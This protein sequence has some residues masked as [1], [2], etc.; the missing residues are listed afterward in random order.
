MIDIDKIILNEVYLFLA[1]GVKKDLIK[2]YPNLEQ[3]LAALHPKYIN[4]LNARFGDNAKI[5]EI[6]PIEDVIPTLSLFDQR[7]QSIK[8]KS[9]NQDFVELVTQNIGRKINPAD[10][11]NLTADEI[12]TIIGLSQRKKQRIDVE[13]KSVIKDEEHIGKVGPWN[14]WLPHTRESSCQIAGYD[15]VTRKEKTTWCTARMSGSNLFYSY[16]GASDQRMLLFYV[17]K[18]DP[19]NNDDWLSVGYVDGKIKFDGQHGGISVNRANVG[20]TDDTFGNIVGKYEK[21]IIN[22]MDKAAEGLSGTHPAYEKIEQAAKSVDAYKYLIKG[23][24]SSEKEDL[25]LKIVRELEASPEVL[26]I[27]AREGDSTIRMSVVLNSGVS[28][29]IL[30]K[31]SRD[32]HRFVRRRVANSDSD[33][34][35]TDAL[36]SL[37]KDI[38]SATRT[39]VAANLNTPPEILS[40]LSKDKDKI[41]TFAVIN[42]PRT[43][44]EILNDLAVSSDTDIRERLA[45]SKNVS[46]EIL[47]IL[48]KDEDYE[49]QMGAAKNPKTPSD[50]LSYLTFDVIPRVSDSNILRAEDMASAIARNKNVTPE[51]IS[52]LIKDYLFSN[53]DI[54]SIAGN[55]NSS[56]ILDIIAKYPQITKNYIPL[57]IRNKAT[58]PK[59]LLR[60]AEDHPDRQVY[61]SLIENPNTPISALNI[62]L[63]WSLR[64]EEMT[65]LR[66]LLE[67]PNLTPPFFKELME[68]DNEMVRG[69]VAFSPKAPPEVLAVLAK[70]YDKT[71]RRVVAANQNTPS[72]VLNILSKD[73]KTSVRAKVATNLSS[74]PEALSHLSK[75]E[76]REMRFRVAFNLNTPPATLAELA[77]DKFYR[78]RSEVA[79]N[80]NTPSEV[81]NILLKDE[82]PTVAMFAADNL[83][84][85]GEL[86]EKKSK[87]PKTGTGKKPKGSGRRLYTDEN[88]K[89]TVSVEFSSAAAIK[90]TLSKPSFKSKSHKRQSQIINLI[91]QRTRAAY[92][93]AKKPE[94]KKRLKRALDYAKQRKEASK[95]KTKRMQKSKNES[96]LI[97]EEMAGVESLQRHGLHIEYTRPSSSGISVFIVKNDGDETGYIQALPITRNPDKGQCLS[98][99]DTQTFEVVSSF[100]APKIRSLGLG[101][102]IYDILL[103]VAGKNNIYIVPDR[104]VVSKK[105]REIWNFYLQNRKDELK[106]A[107]LDTLEDINYGT[108]P[109]L[110]PGDPRDDC[111]S[112]SADEYI[113]VDFAPPGAEDHEE[114]REKYLKEPLTK[115]YSKTNTSTLD[116]HDILLNT[117]VK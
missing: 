69:L 28:T 19:K 10:I 106:I 30:D 102:L 97:N 27:L 63:R 113:G 68:N 95:K 54:R 94:V 34:L 92:K 24:S 87:D 6:H 39:Y 18:D 49:V 77:K 99:G 5:E 13:D 9:K 61:D 83:R 35:S 109:F 81:L 100:I 7:G 82:T 115:A 51:I 84:S 67:H 107:Q 21:Q 12:N 103:E 98:S 66:L 79:A 112:Y 23:L 50:I 74:P 104:M 71:V 52:S 29:E 65:T 38:D 75:E 44:L 105:A 108:I 88:P 76:N 16:I 72:E 90:R 64:F 17:I 93:N 89:D 40:V 116:S 96:R 114:Y 78:I 2:K 62:I 47:A 22:M 32:P 59:T 60:I 57:I 43:P 73:E 86:N 33:K 11:T 31:L 85:R 41:V 25:N 8:A 14:I 45:T 56:E 101:V 1:E 53:Y 48:A 58:L 111:S 36:L 37:S 117:N 26:A 20:L 4:W 55:T 80:K 3:E 42:N 110:T 15:P 46:P 70:D 91:H